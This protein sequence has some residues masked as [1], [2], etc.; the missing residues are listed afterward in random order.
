MTDRSWDELSPE[1]K[2]TFKDKAGIT[3]TPTG[4]TLGGPNA[5]HDPSSNWPS[6]ITE[7]RYIDLVMWFADKHSYMDFE[8]LADG[9]YTK[10]ILEDE[11]VLDVI[12][13]HVAFVDKENESR[14]VLKTFLAHWLYEHE[15]EIGFEP[16]FDLIEQFLHAAAFILCGSRMWARHDPPEN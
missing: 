14:R 8:G 1:E 2:Q 7:D 9:S 4:F 11:A 3:E 16:P 6:F 13:M 12:E 10:A 5:A 15:S